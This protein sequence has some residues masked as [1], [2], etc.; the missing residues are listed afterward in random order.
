MGWM[1]SQD[2]VVRPATLSCA[3]S[4]KEHGKGSAAMCTDA[5][6]ECTGVHE[7][8]WALFWVKL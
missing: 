4:C 6:T 1:D 8:H 7:E 3:H 5:R 2:H